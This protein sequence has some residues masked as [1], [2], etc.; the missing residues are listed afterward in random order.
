MKIHLEANP[1][2]IHTTVL[3]QMVY[4]VIV[5]GQRL[6]QQ[7]CRFVDLKRSSV[8]GLRVFDVDEGSRGS[9]LWIN[10]FDI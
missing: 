2:S 9:I 8:K 5:H 6:S 10:W 1:S 7:Y 4:N 3:L